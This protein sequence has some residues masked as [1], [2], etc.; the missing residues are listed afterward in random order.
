M[1]EIRKE[2][3]K[4]VYLDQHKQKRQGFICIDAILSLFVISYI[5]FFT[6]NNLP[7]AFAVFLLVFAFNGYALYCY[8]QIE[9]KYSSLQLNSNWVD[10]WNNTRLFI[11]IFEW[12]TYATYLFFIG[13]SSALH[14]W[15]LFLLLL[16]PIFFAYF[17][18]EEIEHEIGIHS[19]AVQVH[20]THLV[21][22]REKF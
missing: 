20:Q 8:R 10:R 3:R 14:H 1:V 4:C 12:S 17:R 13:P 5:Y 6:E 18:L 15:I 9:E 16:L 11:C 22:K 21:I 2:A 19:V 7:F